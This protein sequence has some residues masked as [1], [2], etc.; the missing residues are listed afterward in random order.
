MVQVRPGESVNLERLSRGWTKLG[1]RYQYSIVAASW[2]ALTLALLEIILRIVVFS[3]ALRYIY[4]PAWG[5]L[6]TRGSFVHWAIEG[7]GTTHYA[8]DG[9]VAT[10]FLDGTSMVV[11]GDSHTEARQVDDDQNFVSV[12]EQQLR[13]GGQRIDLHNL[14]QDGY[15]VPDYVY[16]APLLEQRYQPAV[17]VIA[18]WHN[19]FDVARTFDSSRGNHFVLSTD[20]SLALKHTAAKNENTWSGNLRRSLTVVDYGLERFDS[21]KPGVV[22]R[23]RQLFNRPAPSVSRPQDPQTGSADVVALEVEALRKAYAGQRVVIVLIPTGPQL[24]DGR[25]VTDPPPDEA[26]LLILLRAVPEWRLVYPVD[27][28]TRLAATGELPHGFANSVPGTGH[29]NVAGHRIIGTFLAQTLKD[30]SP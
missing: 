8:V 9:E 13:Q 16:L 19:D 12:A 3:V 26:Q 18:L 21:I 2:V 22:D 1:P 10:P 6:V 4:D 14:G 20:G 25:L 17:T 28:F 7:S 24:E 5:N 30:L 27:E 29:L 11:I 23:V 15:T